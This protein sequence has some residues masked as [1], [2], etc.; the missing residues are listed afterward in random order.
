M[1][2][3]KQ[4]NF[5][6]IL[7]V[8]PESSFDEIKKAYMK[9]AK[10]YHP[11]KNKGKRLALKRF[12]QINEAWEVL[13]D[14]KKR[15]AFDSNL[16]I[17]KENQ[18]LEKE[19]KKVALSQRA[20]KPLSEKAINLEVPL[21]ISLE[22]ICLSKKKTLHYFQ[23]I[24]GKKTPNTIEFAIPRTARDG[25]HL[26]FKNKGGAS[27]EKK[28]GDLY[29]LLELKTHSHFRIIKDSHDLLLHFPVPF[30]EIFS[31]KTWLLPSP[32]G[33]IC[34]ELKIPYKDGELLKVKDKGLPK[35]KTGYGDLFIKVQIEYPKEDGKKIK[36]KFIKCSTK[37]QK[38]HIENY[39]TKKLNFPKSK[40]FEKRVNKI[41]EALK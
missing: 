23:T 4:K 21:K 25:T 30:L 8:P 35:P 41:K 37:L 17:Y 22:D 27:G 12:Q 24:K 3:K 40:K 34:V 32:Y 6:L 38:A 11:D 5:Y 13:K 18:D 28:K 16:K 15:E 14:Q 29:V 31:K 10:T 19:R 39:K 2:V 9:M 20:K 33:L 26:L 7:Q 1:K 36:E